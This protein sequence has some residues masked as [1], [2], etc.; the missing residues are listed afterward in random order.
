MNECSEYYI[1]LQC[2][3]CLMIV[4]AVVKESIM[5]LFSCRSEFSVKGLKA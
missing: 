1:K 3:D 5:V 2:I 4:V